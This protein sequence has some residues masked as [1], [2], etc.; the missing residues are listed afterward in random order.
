MKI[1]YSDAF[2]LNEACNEPGGA[3][4]SALGVSTTTSFTGSRT[5]TFNGCAIRSHTFRLL[6]ADGTELA[7]VGVQVGQTPTTASATTTAPVPTG[8]AATTVS[9]GSERVSWEAVAKAH[10]YRLELATATSGPWS[11][12]ADELSATTRRVTGLSCG[13][14]HH[15]RVSARG[16]GDPCNHTPRSEARWA[17][18]LHLRTR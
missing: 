12:E 8:L 16:D 5:F 10:R 9:A 14:A 7:R 2:K 3:H 6:T 4:G 17:T 1:E 15:F 18:R 11:V 13:T